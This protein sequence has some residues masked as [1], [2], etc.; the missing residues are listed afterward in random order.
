[1][2]LARGPWY[3]EPDVTTLDTPGRE[4]LSDAW[5]TL[6]SYPPAKACLEDPQVALKATS[7]LGLLPRRRNVVC[8]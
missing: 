7:S 4:Y 1:M 8:R 2:C 3:A 5:M 6:F